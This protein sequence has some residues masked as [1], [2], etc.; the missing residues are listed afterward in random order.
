MRTV[1]PLISAIDNPLRQD[2][3]HILGHQGG[4][5]LEAGDYLKAIEVLQQALSTLELNTGSKVHEDSYY[6]YQWLSIASKKLGDQ[7]QKTRS[8]NHPSKLD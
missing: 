7:I 4:F 2:L 3:P 1:V 8:D 6:L 5:Y